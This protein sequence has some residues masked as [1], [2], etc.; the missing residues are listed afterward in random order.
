MTVNHRD[1]V[2]EKPFGLGPD[3]LVNPVI[4]FIKDEMFMEKG[5]DR[6]T[7]GSG[8]CCSGD[9]DQAV[10]CCCQGAAGGKKGVAWMPC[11][12]PPSL[13]LL[14][15]PVASCWLDKGSDVCQKTE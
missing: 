7:A 10:P 5:S 11:S 15:Q 14:M 9:G 12:I 2:L 3:N 6:S 13:Q 1:K 8:V 4:C